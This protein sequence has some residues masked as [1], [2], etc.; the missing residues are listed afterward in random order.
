MF[1]VRSSRC[2]SNRSSTI[3]RSSYH[4]VIPFR[5]ASSAT[6]KVEEQAARLALEEKIL[7]SRTVPQQVVFKVNNDLFK[8]LPEDWNAS[9]TQSY[10]TALSAV[11]S[12]LKGKLADLVKN[13]RNTQNGLVGGYGLLAAINETNPSGEIKERAEAFQKVLDAWSNGPKDSA[14]ARTQEAEKLLKQRRDKFYK[15]LV[16]L[17]TEN[18]FIGSG[19]TPEEMKYV[20]YTL[21]KYTQGYV[22]V[23]MAEVK[24]ILQGQDSAEIRKLVREKKDASLAA[25]K[26]ELTN[27][28]SEQPQ[29]GTILKQLFSSKFD[30]LLGGAKVK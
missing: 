22:D 19:F 25:D 27:L 2:T 30:S 23:W 21:E 29:A 28:I 13:A 18:Q 10:N 16:S 17:C 5:T 4:S 3:Q 26:A 8:S 11:E 7:H 15:G 6:A 1:A 24:A 14:S 9:H 12:A 20:N